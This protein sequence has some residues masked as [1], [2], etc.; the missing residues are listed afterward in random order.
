MVRKSLQL[1]IDVGVKH[2]DPDITFGH[3]LHGLL[4]EGLPYALGL[5]LQRLNRS[6]HVGRGLTKKLIPNSPE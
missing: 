4:V 5:L 2:L 3:P 1:V 6:D